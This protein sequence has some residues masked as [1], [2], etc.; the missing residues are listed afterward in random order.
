MKRTLYLFSAG[1]AAAAAFLII[2]SPDSLSRIFSGIMFAIVVAGLTFGILPMLSMHGGLERGTLSL[3]NGSPPNAV[4]DG[5][6]ALRYETPFR[7]SALDEMYGKYREKIESQM[8]SGQAFCDVDEYVNEETTALRCW[9]GVVSQIPGTLTGLG[10]LGTFI[11]LITGISEIGFSSVDAAL[12]SVQTLLNGMHIAFYTSVAGVILSI[13]FNILHKIAWNA[14][15][16]QLAVFTDEFHKN[17]LPSAEEQE[18]IILGNYRK[19]VLDRLNRIPKSSG[20]S[21][22]DVGTARSQPV[23]QKNAQILMPQI[24]EGLKKGEFIFVLQPKYD[25][26]SNKMT[27]AEAFVRWNHEKLGTVSPAVFLPIVEENGYITKLD[28]YVWESVFGKVREWI[29]SGLRVVPIA[30]NVS[31][32]DVLAGDVVSTFEGMLAKYKIPPRMIEIEIARNAFADAPDIAAETANQLRSRGFKVIVDGFDGDFIPLNAVEGLEADE[33]KFDMRRFD[34]K[35][36]SNFIKGVFEQ[37]R[38]LH[39]EVTVEGIE[40]MEQVSFL[41]KLGCSIGQGFY[42]SKPVS[43]DEF[44]KMNE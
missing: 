34:L 35:N 12:E 27:S 21:I 44:L 32:T 23:S 31:K 4:P 18:R 3:E 30:L 15:L 14:T 9:N 24:A 11:G 41:R 40:S 37:G 6:A 16:R 1:N 26:N 28:E 43:Q 38:Q 5:S 20:F 29:D 17:V 2:Q 42:F 39:Y 13:V 36:D 7:Q 8:G 25:V 10:I 22:S 33:V 19:D